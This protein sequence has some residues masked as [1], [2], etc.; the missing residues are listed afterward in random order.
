MIL[1]A[2]ATLLKSAG[3]VAGVGLIGHG[4]YNA[5]HTTTADPYTGEVR[6]R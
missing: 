2:G 6:S 4:V 1:L 5:T 3:I